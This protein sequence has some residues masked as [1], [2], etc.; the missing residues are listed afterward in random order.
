MIFQRIGRFTTRYRIPIIVVWVAAAAIMTIVAPNIDSVASSDQADFLP[1]DAPFVHAQQVYQ[2]TFPEGFAPGSTVIVIDARAA[3]GVF[4]TS[5]EEF[6]DQIATPV[7]Q[8]IVALR[9]WLNSEEGPDNVTQVTDPALSPSVAQLMVGPQNDIAIVRVTFSSSN[10]EQATIDA[11]NAIDAWIAEHAPEG[12]AAYQ[13]GEGPIINNTTESVEYSAHLTTRVTIALVIILLLLIYRSPVSPLVPLV[14]VTVAYLISR[15]I[16]AFLGAHVMTITSYANLI[17]IVVMYGAGTDYCL[18]LISRFREEMADTNDTIAATTETVHRVGETIASSAATIFVGFMA[19]VFAEM[20]IF[21]TTGPALAIGIVLSLL[22]G[23]TLVPALLATLGQRA[24]WPGKAHHRATGRYYAAVSQFV[25]SRPLLTIIV[26]VALMA[27][28]S[29][30]ALTQPVSYNLLGDLPDDKSSVIGYELMEDS[31]GA[32]QIAPLTVVVTGRDPAHVA[33]EI[34]ELTGRLDALPLV[35]EVRGLNTP[36]GKRS[37]EF[38]GLLRVDRQLALAGEMLGAIDPSA[39]AGMDPAAL[40]SLLQGARGYFDLLAER[41]PQVADD[42]N[43]TLLRETFGSPLTLIQRQDALPDALAG[44]AETFAALPDAYL[45]PSELGGV[46]AALPA[47]DNGLSADLFGQLTAQYLTADATAFKLDVMLSGNTQGYAAMDTVN[48]IRAILEDYQ[49]GGEAVV[50]GATAINTDIRDTMDRDLVRAILYVMI[51]IFVVLLIMLR[52]V[53]APL[54]LIATVVL[55][56]LFTL[57]L[58]N[59]VFQHLWLQVEGLTWY[60]PFFVFVFLVALGVDYSIFLIGRIKE[61]IPRHGVREGVHVAVA[62][63]GAIITSAGLILAGTFG[64]LMVGE[65]AGLIEIGFAVAAGV[66][67]DT[68]VVRTMLVPALTTVLGR[69]AWWPGP[70]SQRA[71]RGERVTAQPA[72]D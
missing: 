19:M 46:V 9:D 65:V 5:T 58:T 70:L 31:L 50:A 57:G 33:R 16:V 60:V 39:G 29:Y 36:L 47:E 56:F 40:G 7:G 30:Y 6:E 52:S 62:A 22:A 61:E 32:G 53:V 3:G 59:L 68:F 51:G 11:Q 48:D 35:D 28:L 71:R 41:F 67:I 55:S 4:D 21:N 27:P 69:W 38:A 45:L 43:L 37:G 1:G 2:E 8:F 13:T 20:G 26:I 18:F 24:F 42:P 34:A 10:P 66:L 15:G 17:M 64:A 49:D 72:A 63:T 54:Y 14:A 44:L 12:L 25:S 23:L